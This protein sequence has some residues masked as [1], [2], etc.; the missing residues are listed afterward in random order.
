MYTPH[1]RQ[2]SVSPQA[3]HLE[4]HHAVLCLY[5]KRSVA[6][7]WWFESSLTC[8][9]CNTKIPTTNIERQYSSL[10]AILYVARDMSIR[11]I[12][13]Y[14][15]QV[16]LFSSCTFF[17]L[18]I[19]NKLCLNHVTLVTVN[20]TT[21]GILLLMSFGVNTRSVCMLS[22]WYHGLCCRVSILH[23]QSTALFTVFNSPLISIWT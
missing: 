11:Q 3:L 18:S 20:G 12:E 8:Y 23:Y 19:L 7:P 21:S 16:D 4:G 1:S 17:M 22:P 13:I 14:K 9:C 10:F 5:R 6:V 2:G 15:W